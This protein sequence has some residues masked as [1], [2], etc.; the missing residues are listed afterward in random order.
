LRAGVA[1][2]NWSAAL[3][4]DNLFDT[5]TITNYAQVQVDGNNPNLDQSQPQSVQTNLYGFRPRTVGVTL[6][7]RL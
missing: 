7:Y 3:F 2:G 5:K 1:F 6:N 4:V